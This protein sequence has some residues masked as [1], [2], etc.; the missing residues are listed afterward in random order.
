[1]C[2][3]C[4]SEGKDTRFLNGP[5]N[6]LY[7]NHLYKVFK[8]AA[9]PVKLCYVHSIDLFMLGETRFLREHLPFARKLATRSK[10]ADSSDSPFGF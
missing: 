4:Q 3:V 1:M 5:K 9:A 7:T 2:E 8:N 6:Y 10:N